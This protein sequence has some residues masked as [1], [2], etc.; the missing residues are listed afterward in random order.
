MTQS[1]SIVYLRGIDPTALVLLLLYN[2]LKWIGFWILN[3]PDDGYS[4]DDVMWIKFDIYVFVLV[5][6]NILMKSNTFY[7]SVTPCVNFEGISS[8]LG[9]HAKTMAPVVVFVWQLDLQLPV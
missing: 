7:I 1:W 4:P 9:F 3:V 2:T 5:F 6:R 8:Q